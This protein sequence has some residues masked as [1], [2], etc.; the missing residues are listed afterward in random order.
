MQRKLY[1]VAPE[2]QQRRSRE[3]VTLVALSGTSRFAAHRTSRG[4]PPQFHL[5]LSGRFAPHTV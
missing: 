5:F 3:E 1:A 4:T 2:K